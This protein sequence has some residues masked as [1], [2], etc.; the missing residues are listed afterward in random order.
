MKPRNIDKVLLSGGHEVGGL[1]A[2]AGALAGGFRK[3]GIRA[4]VVSPSSL[5]Y[6][7]NELRDPGILKI[8]STTAVFA[9]PLARRAICV[10]H[11]FPRPDAQGW[12]RTLAILASF[13]LANAARNCRL[14]A[15]SDYV[16]AHL[17]GVYNL[18]VDAMIRNPLHPTFTEAWRQHDDRRYLTYVGR[19]H[20]AK[21]VQRLLPVMLRYLKENARLRICIVGDGPLRGNL[22]ASVAGNPR[23]EFTGALECREVCAQLR[24]T[25]VFLSGNEMEPFGIAYLAALSQGCAVAMPACGGGLE[26]AADLIGSQVQLLP[27]SFDPELVLAQLR[28]ASIAA[29]V[30]VPMTGYRDDAVAS[31]YLRLAD[32]IA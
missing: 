29:C 17:R 13:K 8:L 18:R 2:Y 1:S 28:K 21:N 19:L 11:G 22:E 31:S 27:L 6:R 24:R 4:E 15:V 26:I 20:P 14:V 5:C 16:A 7:S 25:K 12:A 32:D 9:V 30:T 3:L 10:A 23:V